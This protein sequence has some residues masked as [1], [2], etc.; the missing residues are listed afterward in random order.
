M[1]SFSHMTNMYSR[2]VWSTN[3]WSMCSVFLDIC[4]SFF[5]YFSLIYL[6]LWSYWSN[7]L[8]V[9]T[10]SVHKTNL[11]CIQQHIPLRLIHP[12]SPSLRHTHGC[13][14][15]SWGRLY[16]AWNLCGIS[17][18]LIWHWAY[19]WRLGREKNMHLMGYEDIQAGI[20]WAGWETD[21]TK[22]IF[23]VQQIL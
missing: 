15:H 13:T 18:G 16:T 12:G 2:L 7:I 21:K 11:L 17:E 23:S 19:W 10:S 5:F 9:F 6:W 3:L 1:T 20:L 8:L 22:I 4:I 14:W